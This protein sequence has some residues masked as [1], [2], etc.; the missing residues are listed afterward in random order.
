MGAPCPAHRLSLHTRGQAKGAVP[1]HVLYVLPC[2]PG[3]VCGFVFGKL[4]RRA[5]P[6]TRWPNAERNESAKAMAMPIHTMKHDG[7]K[8]KGKRRARRK[9][10]GA[11][12]AQTRRASF[13]CVTA[14]HA[15]SPV[16]VRSAIRA[17]CC[18]RVAG[19]W[20]RARAGYL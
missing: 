20:V 17:M 6:V 11:A 4:R 8:A 10:A 1:V 18:A 19:S 15:F 5:R 9:T 2:I 16:A 14:S 7:G 12:M 13:G 3:R